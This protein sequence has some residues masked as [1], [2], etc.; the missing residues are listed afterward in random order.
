MIKQLVEN[1]SGA[2]DRFLFVTAALFSLVEVLF[3]LGV[4]PPDLWRL[5]TISMIFVFILGYLPLILKNITTGKAP[6]AL[7]HLLV[8][9]CGIASSVYLLSEISR[10]EWEYGSVWTSGDIIFGVMFIV[11]ILEL[12]RQSFGPA[13]P[14]VALFFLSYTLFGHLLPSEFFG[15]TGFSFQRVVSF[16]YGPGAIFGV[17]MSVFVRIIF[18]YMLFGSFLT[19]SGVGEYFVKFSMALAG[20]F[21]G[22]P[23][24]VAIFASGLLGSIN[25][26]SVANVVTT[27]AV[28]IPLM[29]RVG[30]KP[31]FAG[32]VEA[33][34]STGGQILPPVMGAGAFIMAEFLQLPYSEIIIAAAVPALLYY[35]GVYCMVDLEAVKDGLKGMSRQERPD[36][37]E[38]LKELYL[39][40]P[41]VVL[42]YELVIVN[43]S[44]IKSGLI[45]IAVCVII[46]WF[47]KDTR[48]GVKKII[49][50]MSDGGKGS[51]SIGATC[52]TAGIVIGAVAITGLGVRFSSVVLNLAGENLMLVSLF[53]ALI[54]TVLG[55]GL[56]TTAA[57]IITS[58]IAVPAMVNMG[59]PALASHLFVFYFA[60]IS[61]I[62]PPVGG[63]FYAG[64]AIAGAPLMKTGFNAMKLGVA[65]YVVPFLFI[66]SPLL[67]MKGPA[68]EIIWAIFTGSIGVAVIAMAFQG[69]SYIGN[70]S[71]YPWQR[72][73]FAAAFLNLITPGL[74]TDLYGFLL[75]SIGLV[76]HPGLLKLLVSK[77]KGLAR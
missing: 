53:T 8:L 6:A 35:L 71:W 72:I 13:L 28:T 37:R 15:H 52:A 24:K 68:L 10:L 45:A 21:R 46:S 36:F 19:A 57:Y 3:L 60:C 11:A 76:T 64:A 26:N 18:L 74:H 5:E 55:M 12:C 4:I 38:V 56:P 16:M 40:V 20:G 39:L 34:A 67:L 17:V 54:C 62:T 47:R 42:I 77:T 50:A 43:A 48:M 49:Y 44:V 25:G 32:A 31:M 61:A 9:C 2:F 69:R 30:Y 29:K 7:W 41:I 33:A 58:V 73:L 63:A 27:G 75:L 59:V 23:A 70:I 1:H 65:A 51:V 22:G 14:L 66:K